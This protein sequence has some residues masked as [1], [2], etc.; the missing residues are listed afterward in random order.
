M[1]VAG[2]AGGRG[3]PAGSGTLSPCYG[4]SPKASM[5]SADHPLSTSGGKPTLYRVADTSLR[6][7]LAILRDVQTLTQRGRSDAGYALFKNRWTSWRGRA[8]E[9]LIRTSLEQ[10]T[11][12]GAVP[13]P[14]AQVVG[15]WWNRQFKEIDLVGA[16]RGPVAD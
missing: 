11:V 2:T 9:P 14:E 1:F 15:G 13:W 5:S 12:T 4:S 3:G 10:A 8:V 6:L 16:D 7:H